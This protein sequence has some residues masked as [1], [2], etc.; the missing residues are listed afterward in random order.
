MEENSHIQGNVKL[1]AKFFIN[2]IKWDTFRAVV[3][4]NKECKGAGEINSMATSDSSDSDNE[5][6]DID[7]TALRGLFMI[8]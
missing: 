6:N 5:C 8:P 3:K 1:W 2:A 4:P 7:L